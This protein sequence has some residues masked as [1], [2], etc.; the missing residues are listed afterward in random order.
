MSAMVDQPAA[1]L[2]QNDVDA[3]PE[4]DVT[5][6]IHEEP[7][8]VSLTMRSRV[9]AAFKRP[10]T[11]VQIG[12]VVALSLWILFERMKKDEYAEMATENGIAAYNAQKLLL[13][14]QA[15]AAQAVINDFVE[16]E[17]IV[18]ERLSSGELTPQ[19]HQE[20]VQQLHDRM[21]ALKLLLGFRVEGDNIA[22][23]EEMKRIAERFACLA[24][25]PNLQHPAAV[26]ILDVEYERLWADIQSG[27]PI[28]IRT[29]PSP[30]TEDGPPILFGGTVREINDSKFVY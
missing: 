1:E 24:K 20:Y 19:E 6:R 3:T 22:R 12:A 17:N 28:L 13:N 15:Y 29:K 7:D 26:Q 27:D 23:I 18:R 16:F 5:V 2:Q 9:L 11:Y 30:P 25:S 8:E 21:G 4:G 14:E 10:R